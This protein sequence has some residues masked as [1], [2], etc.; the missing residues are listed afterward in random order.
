M[1]IQR[2]TASR[3]G[4][5]KR[6]RRCNCCDQTGSGPG[7]AG[8]GLS[9]CL[10]VTG[11]GFDLRPGSCARLCL[12][13]RSWIR[14]TRYRLIRKKER[15]LA[16]VRVKLLDLIGAKQHGTFPKTAQPDRFG[17]QGRKIRSICA[18]LPDHNQWQ[19][20]HAAAGCRASRDIHQKDSVLLPSR[21]L[22]PKA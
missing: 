12:L 16:V 1:T 10:C 2:S 8:N 22:S 6:M 13:G 3:S 20:R 11:R 4:P 21:C 7:Q 19:V 5:E 9:C 14:S 18:S 15:T 17:Q